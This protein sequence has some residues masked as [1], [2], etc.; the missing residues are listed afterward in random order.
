M[1]Q[2]ES[3]ISLLQNI[4]DDLNKPK[5]KLTDGCDDIDIKNICGEFFLREKT[6]I[7]FDNLEIDDDSRT[8][9][10]IQF[11]INNFSLLKDK[12]NFILYSKSV[13]SEIL[14]GLLR[15]N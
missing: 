1:A 10:T 2:T 13:L 15:S 11:T 9:A 8:E 14:N 5:F 7:I 6:K 12:K 4:L 3:G